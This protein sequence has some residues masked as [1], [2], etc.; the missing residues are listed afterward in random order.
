MELFKIV[1]TGGPCAGKTTQINL[2]KEYLESKGYK[3]FSVSE[4]ATDLYNIGFNYKFVNDSLNFQTM[5]L[6][7]QNYKEQLIN[8]NANNKEQKIVVLYDRGMLD[9]KAYFD[10]HSGFDYILKTINTS[11]IDILD[12]YDLVIDLVSLANCKPE[13]YNNISND[14]RKETIEEAS[15]L[16]FKTSNAWAG[17]P[18]F[19]IFNSDI[20]VKEEFSLI[21]D[22]IEKVLDRSDYREIEQYEIDNELQDF[23]DY[24]DDNSRLIDV[25]EY[26]LFNNKTMYKRTYKGST[27]YVLQNT[28]HDKSYTKTITYREYLETLIQGEILGIKK[29]KSLNFIRNM[30]PFEIKFYNNRTVLEYEENKSNKEFILP[31]EINLCK[32]K[33]NVLR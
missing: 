25:E 21:I 18:N 1:F 13:G 8:E 6:K 28:T 3:V 5:I 22:K 14:A 9:N 29:Y 15:V 4:T 19:A 10:G 17:H 31:S 32:Q 26:V 11:E 16:D 2:T 24:N 20:T 7:L 12:S 33:K 27:S 23:K 30:Q